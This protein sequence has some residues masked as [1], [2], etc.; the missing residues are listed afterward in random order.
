MTEDQFQKLTAFLKAYAEYCVEKY[1]HGDADHHIWA[2]CE[3]DL[4]EAF[5]LS[6]TP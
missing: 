2:E 3:Y 6:Q 4:R 5:G 1:Q